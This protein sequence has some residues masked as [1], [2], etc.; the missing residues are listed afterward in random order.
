MGSGIV[1][2]QP[3]VE[4]APNGRVEAVELLLYDIHR[5]DQM[6]LHIEASDVS[7][8][9]SWSNDNWL[10]YSLVNSLIEKIPFEL[11]TLGNHINKVTPLSNM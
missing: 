10:K 11:T 5:F 3:F 8:I 9:V 2:P 7:V 4:C 1:E 6:E